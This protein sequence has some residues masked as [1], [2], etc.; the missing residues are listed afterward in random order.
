MDKLNNDEM[1]LLIIQLKEKYKEHKEQYKKQYDNLET[2]YRALTKWSESEL[3]EY[4]YCIVCNNNILYTVH[5]YEYTDVDTN[6]TKCDGCNIYCCDECLE[7][8]NDNDEYVCVCVFLCI[9]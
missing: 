2:K 6:I 9:S 4:G 7:I 1:I 5:R 8:N 3:L